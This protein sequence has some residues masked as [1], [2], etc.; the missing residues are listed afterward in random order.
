MTSITFHPKDK[1]NLMV[2]ISNAEQVFNV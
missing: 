2:E 1:G